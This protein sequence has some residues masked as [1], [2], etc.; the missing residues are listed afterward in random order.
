MYDM[1][2][3]LNNT[4]V[5][6]KYSDRIGM[7]DFYDSL[8]VI[9]KIIAAMKGTFEELYDVHRPDNGLTTAA[10]ELSCYRYLHGELKYIKGDNNIIDPL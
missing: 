1:S 8:T 5:Y 6:T 7:L 9:V 2:V 3:K 4:L 10:L